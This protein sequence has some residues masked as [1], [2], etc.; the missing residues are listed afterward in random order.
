MLVAFLLVSVPQGRYMFAVM[1]PAAALLIVGLQKWVP[2]HAQPGAI[3][4]IV[5]VLA[6]LDAV[7]L[8]MVLIPAYS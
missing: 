3:A 8:A 7:G 4:V 5:A 2:A 1:L 6:S